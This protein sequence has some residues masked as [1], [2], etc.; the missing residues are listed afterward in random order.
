[1]RSSWIRVGPKPNDKCPHKR[2]KRRGRV[3]LERTRGVATAQEHWGHQAGRGRKD[4]PPEP[5]GETRHCDTWVWDLRPPERG[6]NTFLLFSA[7]QPVVLSYSSHRNPMRRPHRGSAMRE[8]RRSPSPTQ[9]CTAPDPELQQSRS[10]L[11][12]ASI[13]GSHHTPASVHTR[14]AGGPGTRVACSMPRRLACF[15]PL[16]GSG[17]GVETAG[18]WGRDQAEAQRDGK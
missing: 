14:L 18:S 8:G 12:P 3:K 13:P 17:P 6:R 10:G 4:P 2:Q 1:M 16:A 7:S 5:P 11:F 15:L 9:P